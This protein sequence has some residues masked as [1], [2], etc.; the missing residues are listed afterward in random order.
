MGILRREAEARAKRD[1][2]KDDGSKPIIV[3]SGGISPLA[4]ILAVVAVI[5]LFPML[6]L[7]SPVYQP[8]SPDLGIQATQI[9]NRQEELINSMTYSAGVTTEQAVA[10]QAEMQYQQSLLSTSIAAAT[11]TESAHGTSTAWSMT[12]TPLAAEQIMR[13]LEL[14]QEMR[15]AY[16]GQFMSPLKVIGLG[17]LGFLVLVAVFIGA[18]WAFAQFVPVF[19]ARM[20]LVKED[21]GERSIHVGNNSLTRV[22]LMHEPV[23]TQ[24]ADGT[25]VASGGAK[26]PYLQ[27]RITANAARVK[28]V[29]GYAPGTKILKGSI[30]QIVEP[31]KLP[32]PAATTKQVFPLPRWETFEGWDG[33]RGIP[34]GVTPAGLELMNLESHPHVGV[35]GKTGSGK[36]RRFLR[37]FL[38]GALAGGQ[39]VVI[40]GKQ[41]DYWP[42]ATHPNA[43]LVPVRELT[44]E[45]EA[46]RYVQL[47]RILVEE[48]NRRDSYLASHHHST[49]NIAGREST[50]IVL[51]ELGNAL[52]LMPRAHAELSYRYIRGLTKEGRKVGLNIVFASQRAKGFR[53]IMTQVGRAVF[54][55]EDEQ[56]SRFALGAS[57]AEQLPEGYFYS[58]FGSL[59][60]TGAFD[61]T[62]EELTSFLSRRPVKALEKQDWI[63]VDF[64]S[65]LTSS[66]DPL[67]PQGSEQPVDEI[68]EMAEKVR[69]QWEPGLSLSKLSQLLGRPYAGPSWIMKVKKVAEYL[70]ATT[71]NTP[72][73]GENAG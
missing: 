5:F 15:D 25:M 39:R 43:T 40:V 41:V 45:N 11:S 56:E 37:P 38:A 52:D 7:G 54:F 8:L 19:V 65:Q 62:D 13:D 51:D 58:R 20:R 23:L 31:D 27:E 47:L 1:Q 42:F 73:T 61:P 33:T 59:K 63:D 32:E 9:A 55:V 53:D 71:Q 64:K 35:L 48:M 50:L 24:T 26:D 21:R 69:A 12:Q 46:D 70:T 36:S 57:G 30:P 4:V 14:Q 44:L 29:Q 72:P 66:N 6:Q 34:F 3:Q 49:W 16:W 2:K 18:A 67:L 17:V 68:K 28:A 60:L 10:A 22:D